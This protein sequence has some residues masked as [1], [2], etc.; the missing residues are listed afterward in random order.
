[1]KVI[2][3]QEN[4]KAGLQMVGRVISPSNSLPILNNLLI[5]TQDGVLKISSTN[6]EIAITTTIRCKTEE[7]G[8]VTVFAKTITDLVNNLPN[9]NVTLQTKSGEMMVD[10]ENYHTTIKTLPAEEFPLIPEVDS[11]NHLI[12]NTQDLK[13]AFSQ[14]MFAVS[15]NQTQP[16]I[17]GMLFSL[18]KD[19][20]KVVATDRYRLAERIL[21][22]KSPAGFEQNIIIPHKTVAE[23]VRVI[24][25]YDGEADIVI[26]ETQISFAINQTQIISRLIDGQYP[27]YQQIIPNTFNSVININRHDL[28]NAL[29][30]GGVFS[31]S[32]NSITF[33]YDN[34]K[35][36]LKITAETQ[37]LGKSAAELPA[38]VKG[39][40]GLI[41]L[42]HRYVLDCLSILEDDSV[43]IKVVNDTSPTLIL[44]VENKDYVY[45]VMPIKT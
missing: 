14:V 41:I 13:K 10:V 43:L 36:T 35:N 24:G 38:Q 11:K 30:T 4:L 25:N 31:Q 9:K 37:D 21:K 2:C 23:L 26:N 3:T 1:M 16:E 15:T 6:L 5:K 42:N 27:P 20:L 12:L 32:N 17:S 40:N 45:L 7:E 34:T 19:E 39:E 8:E 29:K 33:E 18:Q 28:V 44:P 22:L